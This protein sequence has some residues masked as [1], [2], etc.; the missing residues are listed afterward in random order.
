MKDRLN[1]WTRFH[2]QICFILISSSI[3]AQDQSPAKFQLLDEQSAAPVIG[4]FWQYGQQKGS[5]DE[6]GIIEFTFKIDQPMFLSHL[7]YGEWSLKVEE[8]KTGIKEGVIRLNPNAKFLQPV[9]IIALRPKSDEFKK[10]ELNDEDRLAHDAGALLRQI[11]GLNSIQK[12]GA[13][14]FDPVIR[15]FK[16]DQINIVLDGVQ[17]AVAACPNRMDP[18]TS[19]MAPNMIDRI[20]VLKGPHQLRYGNAFGATINFAGVQPEFSLQKSTYGRISGGY[21]SNGSVLRSEALLGFTGAIYDIGV[22]TSWSQGSD[23]QTGN[24]STVPADFKRGSIGTNIGLKIASGQHV[25]LSAI[26]NLARNADF[27]ALAMD[28]RDDD[29]WLLKAEHE[30]NFYDR[31]LRSLKTAIFTS[32]VDHLMDNRLKPLEPRMMYA[33]TNASTQALGGRTEAMWQYGM[34]KFYTGIDVRS[35]HAEG[36]RVREFLLGPNAGKTFYDNAWQKGGITKSALFSEYQWR[37]N[38]LQLVLAGRLEMNHAQIDDAQQEFIEVNP[39]TKI[40]QLNPSL[41]LGGIKNLQSNIA[42]GLWL[43]RAQRSG[44][45]TERYINYLAVGQDPYELLGNPGLSPEVNHQVDLTFQTRSKTLSLNTD[46]FISYLTD[47]ISSRILSD[48]KPKL[49]NSPGVR[50]FL[51]LDQALIHGFEVEL[52]HELSPKIR[53]NIGIAYTRGQDLSRKEPLP[54]IAPLELHYRIL[55]TFAKNKLQ[56]E[57]RLRQVIK[58]SR[59]SSEYGETVTPSFFLTDVNAS[60]ALGKNKRIAAGIQNLFDVNYYEHLTRSV[61]GNRDLPI[62]APGRNFS[63]TLNFDFR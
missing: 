41:S 17:S 45:L 32:L 59:I 28:L 27:P 40:N 25:R 36:I 56:P 49:P 11:T 52:S 53:Q 58:Q 24:G 9:T 1:Q 19:Q 10:M 12:G 61:A 50:Q 63:I 26:R 43:G 38:N 60:Y 23:Y 22:F 42:L 54:E 33:E 14:G 7:T 57:I 48:I 51:N 31:H 46:L 5:S 44:N 34:N 8:L 29:T 20:E 37:K 16:Y 35:E 2:Y 39:E 30:A 3:Y 62:Y 4:A 18:A 15:G 55:G 21:E 13:Y 47:F 6:Q